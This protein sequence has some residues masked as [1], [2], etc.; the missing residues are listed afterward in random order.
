VRVAEP[1]IP[2]ITLPEIHL[3]ISFDVPPFELP[4]LGRVAIG[5][6]EPTIK[7]FGAL[8]ALGV[9]IGSILSVKR[10]ALRGL[11]T[12]KMS[13]FF[14]WVVGFGFIGAHVFDALFYHPQ[15]VLQHP[16]YLFALWDGL[17]SYG[18]FAGAIIGGFAYK[19][20][21]NENIL[22]YSDAGG[23][24]FTWGWV[25]GR[26]GCAIV[27]DHP[28]RLSDA[29]FA[30]KYPFPHGHGVVGRYDLGLYELSRGLG[31]FTLD[32]SAPRTRRSGSAST[33]CV[34]TKLDFFRA[35]L[36][37]EDSRPRNGNRLDCSRSAST[38]CCT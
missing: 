28:G 13:E 7:P 23:S 16:L 22:P 26:A 18:G 20:A 10:A 8:V 19:Y 27:H 31:A 32:S 24:S 15:R 5:H 21:K 37:T 1:L 3:G 33:S 17:S 35:I 36:G 14:F 4:L 11:D 29:W 12:K 34:R 30:V 2:Y 38:S 6:V 25:F 9:Y